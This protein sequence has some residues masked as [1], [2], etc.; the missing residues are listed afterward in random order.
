MDHDDRLALKK[1]VISRYQTIILRDLTPENRKKSLY[2]GLKRSEINWQRLTLFAQSENLDI[3]A[4]RQRVSAALCAFLEEEKRSVREEG[5]IS[6]IN[7]SSRTVKSFIR[8][9][10][11]D[12]DELCCGW[13]DLCPRS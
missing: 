11:V 1:A 8:E 3:E 5:E 10:G 4:V 7:C 13:E 2:R 6:C 9:L 12:P